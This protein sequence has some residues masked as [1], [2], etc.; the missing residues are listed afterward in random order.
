M[1]LPQMRLK[2][3]SKNF[4]EKTAGA[5]SEET[6]L[7]QVGKTKHPVMKN[8]GENVEISREK[9]AKIDRVCLEIT[10][11]KRVRLLKRTF[12]AKKARWI[13]VKITRQH[14]KDSPEVKRSRY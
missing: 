13:E 2:A 9:K 14:T 6:E 10:R 1:A 3:G 5:K 11:V 7:V 4:R 12:L 8:G